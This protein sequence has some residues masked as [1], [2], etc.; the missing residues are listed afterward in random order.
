MIMANLQLGV[1]AGYVA[2]ES[3]FATVPGWLLTAIGVAVILFM[4]TGRARSPR[5]LAVLQRFDTYAGMI[6]VGI[7]C[8]Q[9]LVAMV[10]VT[11]L[12]EGK[13]SL[14]TLFRAL[15]FVTCL[16]H[17][18]HCIEDSETAPQ[19][20]QARAAGRCW[21]RRSHSPGPSHF[22]RA[23]GP[24]QG[25]AEAGFRVSSYCLLITHRRACP[26][27]FQRR[28]R[29]IYSQLLMNCGFNF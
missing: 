23:L 28:V 21:E 5:T 8:M 17:L 1:V 11:T 25:M 29:T 6:T 15:K 4:G 13:F 22:G 19:G 2:P 20:S 3:R 26:F 7:F 14:I 9:S 24:G 16:L 12:Q 27:S 10:A 18:D